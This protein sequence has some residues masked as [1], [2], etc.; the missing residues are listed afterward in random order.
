[1]SKKPGGGSPPAVARI[2]RVAGRRRWRDAQAKVVVDAWKQSGMS[3]QSFA[4]EHGIHHKRLER[5]SAR[6]RQRKMR[7]PAIP[8]TRS[9]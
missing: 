4:A 5:W 1:M 6:L 3:L 2:H 7:I 8:V 9:D